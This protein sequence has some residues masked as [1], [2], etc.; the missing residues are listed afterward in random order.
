MKERIIATEQQEITP[1]ETE[2]RIA[3]IQSFV[4]E[5]KEKDFP[6]LF[7]TDNL[8]FRSLIPLW[9]RRDECNNAIIQS[10]ALKYNKTTKTITLQLHENDAAMYNHWKTYTFP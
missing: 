9:E 3:E 10:I 8:A 2:K 1:E 6:I 7:N 5:I 4:D